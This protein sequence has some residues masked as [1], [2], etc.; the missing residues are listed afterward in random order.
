MKNRFIY[1]SAPGA[2][3]T[4]GGD[5]DAA[6]AAA[7]AAA[8]GAAVAALGGGTGFALPPAWH[9]QINWLKYLNIRIL[10]KTKNCL[11]PLQVRKGFQR[12]LFFLLSPALE[13]NY[14]IF[15]FLS[16]CQCMVCS[17]LTNMEKAA[18]EFK[19]QS[20]SIVDPRRVPLD[21]LNCRNKF[22]T[23]LHANESIDSPK[24]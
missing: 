14:F 20:S 11:S 9:C 5:S 24:S 18:A 16:F 7:V 15:Y 4:P 21:N 17:I 23:L 6:D 10:K 1:L 2:G 8:A 22:G 3:S 13:F 12:L 19:R